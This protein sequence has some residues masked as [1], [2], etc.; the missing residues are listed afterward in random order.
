MFPKRLRA[1]PT[2]ALGIEFIV[3]GTSDASRY[4]WFWFIQLS[5]LA[6]HIW[7]LEFHMAKGQWRI[8]FS[9]SEDLSARVDSSALV[10]QAPSGKTTLE[11][12]R[13]LHPYKMFTMKPMVFIIASKIY[14]SI[15]W[16]LAW[17]MNDKTTLDCNGT[18]HAKLEITLT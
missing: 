9:L 18:L 5:I 15:F 1:D 4:S 3:G 6:G 7:L 10:I 12:M 16:P 8:E 17:L 2:Q 11:D 13:I 14:V